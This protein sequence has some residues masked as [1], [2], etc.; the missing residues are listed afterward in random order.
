MYLLFFCLKNFCLIWVQRYEV[1][2]YPPNFLRNSENIPKF[3]AEKENISDLDSQIV[4]KQNK[5]LKSIKIR[6]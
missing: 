4:L 5:T 1:W 2:K 6:R 3:A